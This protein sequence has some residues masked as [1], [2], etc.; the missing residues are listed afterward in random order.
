MRIHSAFFV[1][2]DEFLHLAAK[3]VELSDLLKRHRDI[4]CLAESERLAS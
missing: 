4:K 3:F 2:V 1:A